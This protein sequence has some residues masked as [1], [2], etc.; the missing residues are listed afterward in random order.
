MAEIK[1]GEIEKVIAENNEERKSI[2]SGIERL[3][4]RSLKISEL[5]VQYLGQEERKMKRREDKLVFERSALKREKQEFEDSRSKV[6]RVVLDQDSSL[7]LL[8]VGGE[9]FRIS[10]NVLLRSALIPPDENIILAVTLSEMRRANESKNR[11]KID[12]DP[13]FFSKIIDY[14]RNRVDG[15]EIQWLVC[16]EDLSVVDLKMIRIEVHY[17]KIRSLSNHITWELVCREP[18]VADL[19]KLGFIALKRGVQIVG[20]QTQTDDQPGS[21]VEKNFEG[22][23]IDSVVFAHKVIFRGCSF[24]GAKFINCTF[25]VGQEF[26]D[27][28]LS[29]IRFENCKPYGLLPQDTFFADQGCKADWNNII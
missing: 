13:R 19:T 2:Q 24:R 23:K 5:T 28:N 22:S 12:R 7:V 8:D 3:F 15:T 29:G 27:C 6:I 9:E 25:L 11:I 10:A 18:K 16:L 21:V 17:Y 1:R 14:L 20:Y 4:Q 26:Y